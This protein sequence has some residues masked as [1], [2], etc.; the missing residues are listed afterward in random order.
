MPPAANPAYSFGDSQLGRHCLDPR[1]KLQRH[2]HAKRI[3]HVAIERPTVGKTK[4]LVEPLRGTKGFAGAGFET[5]AA[6]AAA[7]GLGQ[8]VC[9]HRTGDALPQVSRS[10]AHRL[11]FAV[12]FVEFLECAAA[13]ELARFPD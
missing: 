7:A 2:E 9:E 5:D 6:V 11:D 12:R 13:Q 10:G 3:F 8:D 1:L 4:T